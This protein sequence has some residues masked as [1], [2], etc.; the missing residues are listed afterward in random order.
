MT[1]E[2]RKKNLEIVELAIQRFCLAMYD[3]WENDDYTRNAE[4]TKEIN[5]KSAEYE[6]EYNEKPL[7]DNCPYIDD[8]YALRK[9][10]SA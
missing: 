10:L 8:V 1:N 3:H 6:K 7:L 2:K 4:L 5:E 9:V